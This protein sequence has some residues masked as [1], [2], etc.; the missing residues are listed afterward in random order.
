[1]KATLVN[2][3]LSFLLVAS[4]SAL[5]D[6]LYW[7][8]GS[9]RQNQKPSESPSK[10]DHGDENTIILG[11]S[12][13]SECGQEG[14][15]S[16]HHHAPCDENVVSELISS[17][18]SISTR[19]DPVTKTPSET[20]E[21]SAEPCVSSDGTFGNISDATALMTVPITYLYEMQTVAGT[22]QGKIDSEVLPRLEKA[23]VDSILHEFFPEN[24][25]TTAIGKRKQK[26]KLRRS[27]ND[28]LLEVIGVSMYPPDYI[29]AN[30]C[31]VLTPSDSTIECFVLQGELTI[32]LD[33]E[34]IVQEQNTID[35]L[36]E[37]NMNLGVYNEASEEIVQ[38]YY[39][40]KPDPIESNI[41]DGSDGDGQ[42]GKRNNFSLRMGLFVGI[43]SLAAVLA[44]VVFRITR[45]TKNTDDQ[46]EVQSG[47]VQTYLDVD[48][49]RPSFS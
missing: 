23:I 1:M 31:A 33:E 17:S 37:S 3:L 48:E 22:N 46:T 34:Q 19:Y 12:E 7:N 25:V 40:E 47:V 30:S 10:I 32:F 11:R 5:K 8:E 38:L 36:I 4:T 27:L 42:V 18:D 49:Q 20:D 39:L 44:G 16:I 29:T 24:C 28:R 21:S 15:H 9:Y 13:T 14:G 45:K 41:N 6:R 2:T 43:G 26:R 35:N